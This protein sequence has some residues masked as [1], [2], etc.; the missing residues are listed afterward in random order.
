LT[1]FHSRSTNTLSRQQ[2]LPSMLMA[3][4]LATRVLMNSEPV[5]WL[6]WSVFMI[7]GLP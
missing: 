4:P 5:N 7:S 2:P 1:D 3:M 6:H